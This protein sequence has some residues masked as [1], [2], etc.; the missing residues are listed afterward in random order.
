MSRTNN[1]S[2]LKIL[3]S[4]LSLTNRNYYKPVADFYLIVFMEIKK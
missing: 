2:E 3:S 4:L 1:Y